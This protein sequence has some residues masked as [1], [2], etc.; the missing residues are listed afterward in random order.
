M[1]TQNQSG[2]LACVVVLGLFLTA[3]PACG[4]LAITEAMSHAGINIGGNV[5]LRHSD[6]W[7][8]TNFGTNAIPLD[9][10]RFIDD[11]GFIGAD[12]AFFVGKQVGPGESIVLVK[13]IVGVVE[14]P[15]QFRAWWGD[16]NLPANLQIYFYPRPGFNNDFDA[17]QL[18][19]VTAT[20]TTLVDRV[21]FL[22][23]RVGSTFTYDPETSEFG[24]FSLPGLNGAFKAVETDDIGSPG[25]TTGPVPLAVTAQPQGLTVDAGV[26]ATFKVQF[27]GVPRPRF[28]WLKNGVPISGATS[29]TLT[30]LPALPI[31]AG[32]YTVELENGLTN[33]ISASA[34]LVV[35]T[36]PE[37][38][39]IIV[40]PVDLSITF[41]QTAIFSSS[42]RGYPLPGIQWKINGTNIPDETNATLSIVN[43]S[44]GSAG[45]YTIRASN[46]LCTN[47]ATAHLSVAAK[48]LLCVTE[49]MSKA[50]NNTTVS[51]HQDWWEL[52]SF[53]AVAINLRGYRFNDYPGTFEGCFTVTNDLF[54]QPGESIIFAQ[55][56]SPQQFK[57]WWGEES[58]PENLQ[59][60]TYSG[61][62]FQ[63]EGD[64]IFLWN[65]AAPN[66]LDYIASVNFVNFSGG[67]SLRFL[68]DDPD[69]KRYGCES[70]L[71]ELGA[72]L[73]VEADDIGSPGYTTNH[74]ARPFFPR[75]TSV[76]R[77]A[78][79]VSLSWKTRTGKRFELQYKNTLTDLNWISLSQHLA[80]GFTLTTQDTTTTG[81]TSRFY[82]LEVIP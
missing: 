82:R 38:A 70:V 41:G 21:D 37:C 27:R 40:P 58:L 74:V 51:G 66:R 67:I 54:I 13:S 61:N 19:R 53:D 5:V 75:F 11:T 2:V 14:T 80:T 33:V 17:V 12:A 7:E 73:A 78:T 36:N 30:I 64:A 71:G 20:S 15:A 79:G 52:T 46:A 62:N 60:L 81:A 55:E 31:A 50:S 44:A 39:R 59:I 35:N 26:S 63:Q 8:L 49:A 10:Y 42:V 69:C 18:F 34:T 47:V 77:D 76:V 68:P 25:S 72:I 32:N 65:S 57:D 9:E 48:P 23:A 6:F 4:Q 45:D 24:V 29:N 16:T 1:Q 56:M 43:A 22:E 3:L 28:Q